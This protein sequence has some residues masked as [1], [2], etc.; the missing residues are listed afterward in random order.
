M[1]R[2]SLLKITV[3]NKN[4]G[5]YEHARTFQ[6]L[7]LFMVLELTLGIFQLWPISDR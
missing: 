1:N 4:F 2:N 6:A 5:Q 7:S 3:H